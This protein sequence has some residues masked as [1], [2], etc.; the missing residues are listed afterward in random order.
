[1]ICSG[2]IV[3]SGVFDLINGYMWAFGV[4]ALGAVGAYIYGIVRRLD[5]DNTGNKQ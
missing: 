1:M 2:N 5:D 4:V 3:A